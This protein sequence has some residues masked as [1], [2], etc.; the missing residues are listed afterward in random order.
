MNSKRGIVIK[1]QII[2]TTGWNRDSC[3]QR[4]EEKETWI[5]QR[6]NVAVSMS[7]GAACH[8]DAAT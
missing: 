5:L 1:L 2:S 3:A 4:L 6:F 8:T 7:A